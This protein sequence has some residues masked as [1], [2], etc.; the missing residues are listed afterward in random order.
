M[1]IQINSRIAIPESELE[2]HFTRSG[3]PGGQNV[4]KVSSRVELLFPVFTSSSLTEDEKKQIS[5]K[6][7][8]R[9]D[10]DGMLHVDSQESRSQWQNRVIVVEKFADLLRTALTI[11][12]KRHA[13]KPTRSSKQTRFTTKKTRGVR[14]KLRGKVHPTDD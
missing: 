8:S 1:S 6:L 7:K 9:I 5:T 13:T 4:N 14:K 11:L 3:G 2:F 10:K 12:R